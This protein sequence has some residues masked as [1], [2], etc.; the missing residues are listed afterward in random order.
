MQVYPMMAS[1][2][3]RSTVISELR[4]NVLKE[5]NVPVSGEG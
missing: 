4:L 1:A 5:S 2:V 3:T